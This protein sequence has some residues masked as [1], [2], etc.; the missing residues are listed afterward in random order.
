M[1]TNT[2]SEEAI[3]VAEISEI[4]A[5]EAEAHAREDAEN[6]GDNGNT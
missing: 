6:G 5:R 1:S 3:K 4:R 2:E